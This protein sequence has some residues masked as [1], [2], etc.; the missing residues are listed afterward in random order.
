MFERTVQEALECGLR[1]AMAAAT[2]HETFRL[3]RGYSLATSR[4][5]YA[6]EF[7]D[8]GRIAIFDVSGIGAVARYVSSVPEDTTWRADTAKVQS[9][10]EKRLS[11]A[12]R[13]WLSR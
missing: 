4:A 9:E 6:Y 11:S 3:V 10:P 5:F 1:D 8:T 7:T 13:R 12:R 2:P